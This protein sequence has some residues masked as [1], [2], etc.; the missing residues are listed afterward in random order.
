MIDNLGQS[1]PA[2][3]ILLLLAQRWLVVVGWLQG[4]QDG[5]FLCTIYR[6]AGAVGTCL[7]WVFPPFWFNPGLQCK[8]LYS[9][10]IAVLLGSD[11]VPAWHC[12]AAVLKLAD[13]CIVLKAD[14]TAAP[15]VSGQDHRQE[16][17]CQY[18]ST[19][20]PHPCEGSCLP[21]T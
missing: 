16:H 18:V 10:S 11:C 20:L 9:L 8:R 1:L 19:H 7:Y 2:T 15:Q 14:N 21:P 3:F 17:A 13:G 5:L 4:L 6:R 12:Q